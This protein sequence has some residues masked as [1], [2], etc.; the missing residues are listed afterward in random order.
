MTQKTKKNS[1]VRLPD[2]LYAA[3][4]KEQN[5]RQEGDARKRKI[6]YGDLLLDAWRRAYE[7]SGRIHETDDAKVP[8]P[9]DNHG[10]HSKKVLLLGKLSDSSEAIEIPPANKPLHIGLEEILNGENETGKIAIETNIIAFRELA[11]LA[12]ST[13]GIGAALDAL[14]ARIE[15]LRRKVLVA[16]A[17][18]A[19]GT[20]A[21]TKEADSAPAR[22]TRK[23]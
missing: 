16:A 22:R 12:A 4:V 2:E 5:A 19:M 20:P 6:P 21:A 23:K 10:Q 9:D 11:P 14:R 1:P 7:T 3:L 13:P 8:N 15:I 18:G 17:A